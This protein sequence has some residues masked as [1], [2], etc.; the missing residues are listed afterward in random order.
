MSRNKRLPKGKVINPTFYVFCEG[1][2]EEAYINYLRSK[3]RLPILIDAKI[4]GN[5]ITGKYIQNY[6]KDKANHPKDITYLVY[7]IDVTEMLRKLQAIK[8]TILLSSNPCFELW[9]L[10][11]VQEQTAE[12]TSKECI[13]KLKQQFPN[14]GKGLFNN[15]LKNKIEKGQSKAVNIASKLQEFKNPSS[16][17]F[18][19]INE[20]EKVKKQNNK[21]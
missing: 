6:K 20:I 12:I 8:N 11:H 16:Q 4:A 7:D 17:M 1:E 19:F 9:Y 18:V 21:L 13:Q 10:L 14:Y 5:R 3:Y 15:D 2:T